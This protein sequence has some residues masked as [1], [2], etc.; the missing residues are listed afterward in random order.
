MNILDEIVLNTKTKLEE[1]K[2]LLP[3]D[4]LFSKIN[5]ENIEQSNFKKNL[6]DKSEAIIAEI[7]KASL[8]SPRSSR[9]APRLVCRCR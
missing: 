9:F 5:S 7:K 4:E 2:L 6:E 8:L 1:K 3:F